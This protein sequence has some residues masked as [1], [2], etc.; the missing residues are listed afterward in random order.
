MVLLMFNDM[1]AVPQ[2]RSGK[3]A[4]MQ[5]Y[6]EELVVTWHLTNVR[7]S[8]ER[9]RVAGNEGIIMPLRPSVTLTSI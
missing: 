8:M 1:I 4:G 6:P 2:T 3:S 7:F 9:V 5:R